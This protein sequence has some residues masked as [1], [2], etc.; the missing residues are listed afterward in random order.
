MH[1]RAA[2]AADAPAM[3]GLF[4]ANHH[5]AL[6]AE[7]RARQG[8]VQ[9][10]LDEDALRAMAVGGGLL[11]ADD[12]GAIAGL[13]GL[14]RAESVPGPP[15]PVRALLGAKDELLWRG[16]PLG[17]A[18][19]LLYGPVVVA[20]A[21]RGRGIARGLFDAGLKAASGRAEVMVAFIEMSNRASWTVHVD[22]LGMTPLGEFE[23]GDR[24]YGVVGAACPAP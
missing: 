22:G 21:Y 24:V 4:A 12:G 3:A 6:S 23:L 2:T 13:L 7:E 16:R 11:V 17:A 20:A 8:F 14:V 18:R 19:W 15:P 5:D 9:G 10:A 1:Y